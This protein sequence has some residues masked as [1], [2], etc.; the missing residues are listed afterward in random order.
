MP[1]CASCGQENPEG[2]RFCGACGAPLAAAP[3]AEAEERKVVTVL[4]C[5]LVGFTA[6]SDH[7]D[8]EDVGAMVRPYHRRLR[9]EIQRFGGTLEK[10]IG[11]AVMAVFGAPAAHEDDPERAVHCAL[12]MLEAIKELNRAQ[13]ALQLSVRIGATTGEALVSQA[14]QTEGVLGDVVNT[15]ARLQGVAPVD[16]AVV[17]EATWR[18]TR[19]MFEYQELEPVRVKG[20]AEPV[21]IWRLLGPRSL[22]GL[23]PGRPA[24]PFVGRE[25]E[26]RLLERAYE[27]AARERACEVVTILGEP[28]VGKSRLVREL[29]AL[30]D[31]RPELVAW[32]QGRCLPYGDGI[33]FWALG[34][35]VRAQA[36]VRPSDGP[37]QAAAR[38]EAA[39]ASLVEDP[40]EREWFKARLGPLLGLGQADGTGAERAES[41]TAWRPF[42]Q[43]MAA[44]HP[45]VLVVEDLH[46]A[47][48]AMLDFLEDLA[49]GAAAG[50]LLLLVTARPELLERRPVWGAERPRARTVALVP[51]SDRQTARLIAALLG[52]P[53]VPADVQGL[54]LERAGGNPLYA[55]EFVRLLTDR[56]LLVRRGRSVRLAPLGEIP[57]PETV[58]ALIAARLDT[59][60][61]ARKALLQDAAVVGR[62]FWPG[63]LAAMGG[64]DEPSVE[65]ALREL[66]RTELVRQAAAPSIQGQAE[67]T[68]WH[69]LVRDVAYGQIPRAGRAR[70][71]RAAAA[72]LEGRADPEVV[73]HHYTRALELARAAGEPPERLAELVPATRRFLELAGDR[74]LNLDVGR[75][76]GFYR[77]ALGL[78]RPG[79][80]GR[81]ALLAKTGRTAFQTG[82]LDEAAAAYREAIAGMAE[83]G[84]VLG[85]GAARDR[86]ATVLWSQGDAREAR[87][88]LVEGIRLLEAEP[89]S[90]ELC[91]AY[92]QMAIDRVMSGHAGEALAWADRSLAVADELG[93]LPEIRLRALDARGMARCDLGDLGGV[94]DLRAALRLCH[95]L[96][97]GYDTAVVYNNLSEP[98]WFQE[99]PATALA[100]SR[101]GMDFAERRGLGEATLILSMSLLGPLFDLGRWDEMLAVA[102]EVIARDREHGGDYVAVGSQRYVAQVLLARGEVAAAG[103]VVAEMLPRARAI[104]DLQL[105]IPA[106]I[107]AALCE[108]ARGDL[109]AVA[110]L[111]EELE[112]V[113]GERGSSGWYLVQYLPDLVRLC[114]AAGRRPQAERLLAAV[115]LDVARRHAGTLTGRAL[116]AE[117]AGDLDA[118]AQAHL[119]A[120][121]AWAAY[122]QV[123]EHGWALLGAGRCL[124]R[125]G[126][127]AAAERLAAARAALAGLGAG[128][129][130]AE[131]DACLGDA[132]AG[133]EGLVGT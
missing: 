115:D 82:R 9:A 79:E 88:V 40:S 108:H 76:R 3:K 104:D 14:G 27:R 64:L 39:V 47:D 48:P 46:W 69:A 77:Q 50:A 19:A 17:G 100:T 44:R 33:T 22:P 2:F 93:G 58:Q 95:E 25:R 52:Q 105:L 107:V 75:A 113:S 96:G 53:A 62:A 56:D 24:T 49:A 32:R 4:F 34:Q 70:R 120:A 85:Q 55:E 51:L 84:D 80:R 15:A 123:L 118:A 60:T 99:G 63:A 26:L 86:L 36:G 83:A 117:A 41:F 18:A 21:P 89:S 112:R 42:L 106:V 101:E 128:P 124:R 29:S 129:L 59:L 66:A 87:A 65:A 94:E 28:G 122:G 20:K 6:R 38:L 119:R 31:T 109:P 98:L 71:H 68:F 73:A 110:A 5:D 57:F 132:G 30:L 78:Y 90:P 61:P 43:A 127:P 97:A 74:A 67:Y 111:L 1:R 13:P 125:L 54:L 23:E 45:L 133:T 130:L 103:A 37:E 81:P 126:R 92:S 7:A 35:I 102:R 12:A 121:E 72:W 131:A 8:P 116:L 10:Y 114:L 11:D 16:G 91:S